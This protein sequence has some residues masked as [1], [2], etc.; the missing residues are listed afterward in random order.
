MAYSGRLSSGEPVANSNS[1]S[2]RAAKTV[3]DLSIATCGTLAKE[4]DSTPVARG[5]RSSQVAIPA[6]A[7]L[8]MTRFPFTQRSLKAPLPSSM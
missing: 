7:N 1:L 5:Q 2:S 4:R 3:R 8:G 6:C